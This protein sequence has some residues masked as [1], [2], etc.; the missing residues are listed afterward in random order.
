[1]IIIN[2]LNP[3]AKQTVLPIFIS[4]YLDTCD[5]VLTFDCFMEK[6]DLEKCLKG[7]PKH[8]IGRLRYN[9][10]SMLKTVLFGLMMNGYISLRE[11]GDIC[12]VSI[13]SVKLM[14]HET[15]SYRT[16]GYFINEVI[17][18]LAFPSGQSAFRTVKMA[19]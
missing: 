10:L 3:N 16:F 6:I 15:L 14:K 7:I 9:L 18:D 13:C 19:L 5:P 1:M 17:G 4:D 11:M 12:K 2:K 8:Y